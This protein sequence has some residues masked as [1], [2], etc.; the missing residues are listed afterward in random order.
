MCGPQVLPF[1]ATRERKLCSRRI[2]QTHAALCTVR[3]DRNVSHLANALPL[4]VESRCVCARTSIEANVNLHKEN[5]PNYTKSLINNDVL[6]QS[7][8]HS[9]APFFTK[10]FNLVLVSISFD[11]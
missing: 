10:L 11:S 8:P 9:G 1:F 4:G 7:A 2:T 3:R 6:M 5:E